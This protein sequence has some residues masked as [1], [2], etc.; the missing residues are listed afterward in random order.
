MT[1]K[2][3]WAISCQEYGDGKFDEPIFYFSEPVEIV[4]REIDKYGNYIGEM[5]N[6]KDINKLMP[7][8]KDSDDPLNY[9]FQSL[10]RFLMGGKYFR[11]QDLILNVYD[12]MKYRLKCK[13]I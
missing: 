10:Q 3:V 4:I 11:R 5:K 6:H 13:T 7:Q 1:N 12:I 9:T 2:I 8:H